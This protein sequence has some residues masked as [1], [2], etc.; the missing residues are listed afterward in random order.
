MVKPLQPCPVWV[1]QP[2]QP[3]RSLA[4]Q[5]HRPLGRLPWFQ[6][7]SQ[8]GDDAWAFGRDPDRRELGHQLREALAAGLRQ[9]HQRRGMEHH[10]RGVGGSIGGHGTGQFQQVTADHLRRIGPGDRHDD[11]ADRSTIPQESEPS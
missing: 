1:G 8:G 11:A 4:K 10:H 9:V 3:M 7:G 5:E 6:S 2:N